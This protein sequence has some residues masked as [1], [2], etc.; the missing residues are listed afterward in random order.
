[1]DPKPTEA[2]V[3]AVTI[4]VIASGG[5]TTLEDIVT[6]KNTGAAGVVVGSALYKKKFT[7]TEAIDIISDEN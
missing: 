5:V 6:L 4:P 3:N 1:V 7:L 2:L